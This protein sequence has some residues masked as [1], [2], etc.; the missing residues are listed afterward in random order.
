M[1]KRL[2]RCALAWP[3]GSPDHPRQPSPRL[4][5]PRG[6]LRGRRGGGGRRYLRPD[7][8]GANVDWLRFLASTGRG[9][10]DFPG[11]CGIG[12]GRAAGQVERSDRGR[13]GR[14]FRAVPRLRG[15]WRA[16]CSAWEAYS[17]L[18]CRRGPFHHFDGRSLR[19]HAGDGLQRTDFGKGILGACFIND[20]GTV[21]ALGLIFAPFTYKTVVFVGVSAV[22]L[23]FL[24]S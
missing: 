23:A 19:G 1:T 22:V 9:G 12:A 16:T 20:L 11:R 4:D 2:S 6:D 7:S 15:R 8:L 24:P 3:C 17:E 5:G 14:F 13:P 21:I 10:A 18:A